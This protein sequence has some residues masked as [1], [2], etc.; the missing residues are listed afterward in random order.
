MHVMYAW[1]VNAHWR[2]DTYTHR[3]PRRVLSTLANLYTQIDGYVQEI[4]YW[5]VHIYQFYNHF[6]TKV[7]P[8]FMTIE[9]ANLREQ[10]YLI[11][12]YTHAHCCTSFCFWEFSV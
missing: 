5:G 7:L 6:D 9:L 10:L 4:Q 1:Y 12:V 11:A 3:R 8:K 2:T